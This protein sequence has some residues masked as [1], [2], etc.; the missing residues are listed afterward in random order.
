MVKLIYRYSWGGEPCSGTTII[1]FEYKEK[2]E[3]IYDV[4]KRFDKKF[5]KEYHHA[6]LFGEWLDDQDVSDIENNVFTLEEWFG[7]DKQRP[8]VL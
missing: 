7:K 2:D 1:P 4:L 8:F 6:E 3:F 5:F